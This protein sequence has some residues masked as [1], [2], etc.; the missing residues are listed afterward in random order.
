MRA[1][2]GINI[3]SIEMS[4]PKVRD[5]AVLSPSA[6]KAHA[7]PRLKIQEARW[8]SSTPM[9]RSTPRPTLARCRAPT[10][11]ATL[12]ACALFPRGHDH[13]DSGSI[14]ANQH[15]RSHLHEPASLWLRLIC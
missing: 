8:G 7:I 2:I 9:L 12:R 1:V 14:R 6:R 10:V 5:G 11:G 4:A 13:A 15:D 3:Y